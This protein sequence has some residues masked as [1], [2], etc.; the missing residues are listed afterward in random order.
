MTVRLSGHTWEIRDMLEISMMDVYYG[1]LQALWNVSLTIGDGEIVALIGSNGAGKSTILRT[2]SGL[3]K[4]RSGHIF[5]KGIQ[6]DRQPAHK[7]VDL[8]ISMVPEGR[9]LFPEMTVLENLEMGA[10]LGRARTERVDTL[11]WVYEVFPILKD[12]AKQPA[13]NLSG[14]EQ[15]M[16]AIGRALMSQPKLLLLDE[17]SLGLAPL[18]VQHLFEII[19]QI[20]KSRG[21]TVLMVEQNVY[22]T[23]S[24]ADRGYI[25]ENG[26]IVGQG[27]AK[28]LLSSDNVQDAYLNIGSAQVES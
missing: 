2:V 5:Y 15:K 6:V 25:L 1:D 9:S 3:L 12:R 16:L 20:N 24:L 27:D 21:V 7:I 10:F 17:T 23:L 11:N 13:C 8:G 26:H 19:K 14:G 18:L 28:A 22:M 4:P